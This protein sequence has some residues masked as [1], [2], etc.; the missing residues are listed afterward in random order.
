MSNVRWVKRLL[1]HNVVV[2]TKDGMSL[3]GALIG[4]Y[5]DA[6]V[7]GNASHL[8]PDGDTKIDGQAVVLRD[9]ISWIQTLTTV[10]AP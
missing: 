3:R 5:K 7:L 9:Q 4:E 1:A 2:H 10:E 8:G 6:I